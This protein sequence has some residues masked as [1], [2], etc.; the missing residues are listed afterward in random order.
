[1]ETPWW[2]KV[3]WLAGEV[4]PVNRLSSTRVDEDTLASRLFL[5]S[6][7]ALLRF[8][9]IELALQLMLRQSLPLAV[10]SKQL[11]SNHVRR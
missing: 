3:A 10:Y 8:L 7:H 9:S 2:V 6:D 5:Y 11:A 1:M 4:G